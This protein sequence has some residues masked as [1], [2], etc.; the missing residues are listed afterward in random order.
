[1]AIYK[2]TELDGMYLRVLREPADVFKR[3]VFVVFGRLWEGKCTRSNKVSGNS[4]LGVTMGKSI[5]TNLILAFCD[6]NDCLH[7]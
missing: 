6:K 1:M 7:G 5:L 3:L 4:Q 2:S